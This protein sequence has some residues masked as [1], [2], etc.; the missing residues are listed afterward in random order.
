MAKDYYEILGVKR[1]ATDDELSK[2]YRTLARKH[3]PDLHPDDA[4]AKEKFQEV[5]HA[6]DVLSDPKKREQYDRF[7]PNFESMGG[8]GGGPQGWSS[9]GFRGGQGDVE[10]D[11]NDIFGSAGGGGFADLF[12][13]MGRG[14][15]TR[16][17]TAPRRGS[18][19]EHE[20]TVPFATA[21]KGGEAAISLT[22]HDGK[23][24][25]INIKIPA[26]MEDGKKIR[27]RGQ[28]EPAPAGG[29]AGDL[30]L[31]VHVAP[32]P[33]FERRGARLDVVAPITLSEAVGGAK[34]DV[35]TPHGVVTLS[36]PPGT[37]SGKKLRL[38]GQG[39]RAEGKPP[40]DLYVELQIQL[41]EGLTE[42]ERQEIANISARHPQDPRADLRW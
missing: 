41:P 34:I 32:H 21:I 16:A 20:I 11:L 18:D 8:A 12:R 35:P 30:L 3:H 6:F 22:R 9:G 31:T 38:K 5:Q 29:S 26:G 19:L 42:E 17:R 37:S 33:R 10:I 1:G 7:G 40:G 14:G 39:V 2:A 15:G 25:T 36:V 13:N 24:E 4:S 27:L 28:G 23:N